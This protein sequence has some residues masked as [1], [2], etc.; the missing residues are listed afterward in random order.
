MAAP[1][2]VNADGVDLTARTIMSVE[3]PPK[4][5]ETARFCT[6]G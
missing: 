3:L 4:L 1:V 6:R 5:T 2:F